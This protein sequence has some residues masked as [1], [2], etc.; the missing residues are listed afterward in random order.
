MNRALGL[1]YAAAVAG[2]AGVAGLGCGDNFEAPALTA[3]QLFVKLR[4]LPGVTVQETPTDQPGFHYYI[5]HF[6]Q[7]VDHEDPSLGTFEQ[8]VSLLHR[9]ER[10]KVPMVIATTGYAD[11]IHDKPVELTRLLA[12]NQVSIEHRFFGASRPDPAD[13]TKLTIKQM[14]DDEHAVE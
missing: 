3:E 8:E 5:L 6:T 1:M 2:S 4:Q 14:A 10:A 9:D 7:P 12:A 11:Y 13:W